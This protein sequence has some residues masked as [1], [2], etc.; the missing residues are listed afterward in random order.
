MTAL[1]WGYDA[2]YP[3]NLN[4]AK[5]QEADLDFYVCPGTST[6]RSE[7]GRN[8]NG[9]INLKNAGIEGKKF[10]AKGYLITDW[11]D[12]G[13]FQPKTVGYPTLVLGASYAW[14]YKEEAL[15][16]L[17]FQLN[18]YVFQDTTGFTAKALL[19]LGDAY[20]KTNIPEGNA[21][22]FHLMIRRYKWTMQGHYQTKKL[23]KEGLLA[24]EQE[25]NKGLEL[26][27]KARPKCADAEIILEETEQAAH[28][29]FFG[30][31]LGLAR[32]KAKGM[33]T[34]NIPKKTRRALASELQMV[35]QNHKAIWLVRNREGGLSDSASKLEDVLNYLNE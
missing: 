1:V 15:E 35:I 4:L 23:N 20:L 18:K 14:N 25:I 27:R 8:H 26:L 24:A 29:A 6:W 7:I 22:A 2:T 11:G 21:N 3:F 19:T 12:Y 34:K 5:F 13:H 32:L 10:E 9:F 16:N 31:H 33:K 17:S 30:I 28:L